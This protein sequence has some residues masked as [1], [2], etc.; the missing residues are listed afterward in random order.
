MTPEKIR[1]YREETK[2][3]SDRIHL[4]NAGAALMPDPA[5]AAQ[6]E[7]KKALQSGPVISSVTFLGNALLDFKAKDVNWALW[8]SP[9]YY[10]PEEELARSTTVLKGLLEGNK[11]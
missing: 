2:G 3:C 6:L 11:I 4:S 10:H 9:H 5:T 1:Q 7:V 8:L